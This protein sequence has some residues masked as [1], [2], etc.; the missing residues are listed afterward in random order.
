MACDEAEL[1]PEKFAEKMQKMRA[2][3]MKVSPIGLP[4]V[5][6]Y[7]CVWYLLCVCALGRLH[8]VP[9]CVFVCVFEW[10]G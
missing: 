6:A 1:G 5:L 8:S 2:D 7:M 10:A 4:C 9:P 3:R